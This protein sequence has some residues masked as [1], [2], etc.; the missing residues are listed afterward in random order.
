MAKKATKTNLKTQL[1]EPNLYKAMGCVLVK[2]E[3]EYSEYHADKI[4][5]KKNGVKYKLSIHEIK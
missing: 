2:N 5:F 3:G 4:I 1:H